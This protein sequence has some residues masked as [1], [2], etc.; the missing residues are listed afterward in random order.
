VHPLVQLYTLDLEPGTGLG[1]RGED[2]RAEQDEERGRDKGGHGIVGG[3]RE[4]RA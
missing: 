2:D 4:P 1:E 3:I